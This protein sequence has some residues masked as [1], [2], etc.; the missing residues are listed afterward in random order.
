MAEKEKDDKIAW[1]GK[2]SHLKQQEEARQGTKRAPQERRKVTRKRTERP[3]APLT[4]MGVALRTMKHALYML[5]II[6][7]G[8]LLAHYILTS[9]TRHNARCTVPQL[10]SLTMAEAQDLVAQDEL[11]LII[12]DS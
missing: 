8:A 2:P 6:V 5:L 4:K 10:E 11:K 1:W 7:A 9:V 3:K 12:N